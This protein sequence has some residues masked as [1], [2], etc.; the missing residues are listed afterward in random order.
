MIA[1]SKLAGR[2]KMPYNLRAWHARDILEAEKVRTQATCWKIFRPFRGSHCEKLIR[3]LVDNNVPTYCSKQDDQNRG[4]K[5]TVP[6]S[7]PFFIDIYIHIRRNSPGGRYCSARG[8]VADRIT[9]CTDTKKVESCGGRRS[10]HRHRA[11]CE[12]KKESSGA[13]LRRGGKARVSFQ[14]LQRSNAEA[15]LASKHKHVLRGF[16]GYVHERAVAIICEGGQAF[17]GK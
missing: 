13:E 10:H 12:G 17:M 1:P 16:A 15:R 2:S 14:A 9:R 6:I 5:T 8:C 4:T 7:W 3:R 11:R